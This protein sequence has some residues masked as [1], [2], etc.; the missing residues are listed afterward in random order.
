MSRKMPVRGKEKI[1][2]A[3]NY[4]DGEMCKIFDADKLPYIQV[5]VY[6]PQ[7]EAQKRKYHAQIGDIFEQ[8]TIKQLGRR[9]V[10]REYGYDKCKAMLFVWFANECDLNGEPLKRPPS[11]FTCP[12]TGQQITERS[13]TTEM[14]VAEAAN[15]IEFLNSIGA[16]CG[17]IWSDAKLKK[18]DEYK[19]AQG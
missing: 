14:G 13:S 2:G 5:G 16:D 15:F 12:L 18:Y 10:M 7:K 6:D 1:N 17:V 8:A 19:E 4:A 3:L 9:I 11:Y